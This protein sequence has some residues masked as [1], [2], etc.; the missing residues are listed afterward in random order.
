[1]W[2]AFLF[3]VLLSS[4]SVSTLLLQSF[5][6][7]ICATLAKVCLGPNPIFNLLRLKPTLHGMAG[8]AFITLL[9][10]YLS[11]VSWGNQPIP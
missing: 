4:K 5:K 6:N 11:G 3:L 1:M 10:S 9:S 2:L 7:E 8:V